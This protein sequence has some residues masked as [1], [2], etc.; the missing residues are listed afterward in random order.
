MQVKT[1]KKNKYCIIEVENI[2]DELI[3]LIGAV[4]KYGQDG[5]VKLAKYIAANSQAAK[6]FFDSVR[7]R[8]VP[9]W[10]NK[11]TS[12]AYADIVI[13]KDNEAMQDYMRS[14]ACSNHTREIKSEI[15]T[16]SEEPAAYIELPAEHTLAKEF[17]EAFSGDISNLQ[18]LFN[19]LMAA[20]FDKEE[21]QTLRKCECTA[22][23]RDQG[24]YM[25]FIARTDEIVTKLA[26]A[27]G[28]VLNEEVLE[29]TKQS[30]AY[31]YDIFTFDTIDKLIDFCKAIKSNLSF[32][33]KNGRYI[34]IVK[35][36]DLSCEERDALSFMACDYTSMQETR[37]M[38][39]EAYT[40]FIADAEYIGTS[41]FL[42]LV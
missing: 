37:V 29:A 28:V 23:T 20:A 9:I 14:I 40:N 8:P 16:V 34:L 31:A 33:K 38:C 39:N 26:S 11:Q 22:L 7:E 25:F 1:I 12:A 18:L 3:A 27:K 32:Y 21:E 36:C 30:T 17:D 24:G 41:E 42:A 4:P 6:E 10:F 35:A 13:A 15:V 19:K 2:D 5:I